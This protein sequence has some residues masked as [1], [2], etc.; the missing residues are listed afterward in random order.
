MVTVPISGFGNPLL[1]IEALPKLPEKDAWLRT[2]IEA[3][4]TIAKAAKPPEKLHLYTYS[5][6]EIEHWRG[7][8]F[9]AIRTGDVFEGIPIECVERCIQRSFFFP[10]SGKAIKSRNVPRKFYKWLLD[11]GDQL[12]KIP[13]ICAKLGGIQTDILRQLGRYREICSRLAPKHYVD[14]LHIWTGE[15]NDIEFF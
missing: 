12:L 8:H 1:L 2:Q 10:L 15:L 14:G 3:L 5:E 13:S 4:P 7:P 9:P 11:N 6:L